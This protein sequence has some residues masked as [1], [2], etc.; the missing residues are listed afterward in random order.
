MKPG[1]IIA[2]SGKNLGAKLIRWG[3]KSCYSHLAIVLDVERERGGRITIAESTTFT[4]VR[5]FRNQKCS[6]GV[7][8][9]LLTNWLAAYKDDGQAWWIPLARPLTA[10]NQAKMQNWLWNIESQKIQF[11]YQKAL[12]AWLNKNG[13]FQLKKWQNSST[14]FCSELVVKALQIAEVIGPHIDASIQ[15]PKEAIALPCFQE[16]HPLLVK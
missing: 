4:T 2:F 7:Q 13:G 6:K 14:L 15:T 16:R 3:T 12:G 1:D 5:D 9:H 8:I 11:S 10:E